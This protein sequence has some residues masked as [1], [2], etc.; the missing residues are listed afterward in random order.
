MYTG[1]ILERNSGKT[2]RSGKSWWLGTKLS[3]ELIP[4]CLKISKP[5]Q[6]PGMDLVILVAL[7]SL[8]KISKI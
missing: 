2:F 5:A 6:F 4:S 3:L 8:D 1:S 7:S